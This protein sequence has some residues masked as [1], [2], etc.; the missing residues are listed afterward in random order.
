MTS[1]TASR[2]SGTKTPRSKISSPVRRA[3]LNSRDRSSATIR[4]RVPIPAQARGRRA[5]RSCGVR[6]RGPEFGP[7]AYVLACPQ[8]HD[9]ASERAA[10][11]TFIGPVRARLDAYPD[12]HVYHYAAYEITAL[13][14][15]MGRHGTREA[16]GDD[17]L[18][19]G[20]PAANR[21]NKVDSV[22]GGGTDCGRWGRRERCWSV[23]L[24]YGIFQWGR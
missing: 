15:L 14:R 3:P 20:R 1:A 24:G 9:H 18:R 23:S 13:R 11:E 6:K 22:S 17:L 7:W 5:E 8:A 12:M 19:R 4:E 16:E 10:F 21:L 2:S